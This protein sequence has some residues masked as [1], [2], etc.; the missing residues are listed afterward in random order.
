MAFTVVPIHNLHLPA[1]T[2]VDFGA[3]F[4]F[5]DMPQWVKDDQMLDKMSGHDQYQKVPVPRIVVVRKM[6]AVLFQV[7]ALPSS[8]RPYHTLELYR[9]ALL[10]KRCNIRR[11][12]KS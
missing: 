6:L 5:L 8:V 7:A 4:V 9:Q 10:P 12:S 3:G 1:G 2:Q 11:T